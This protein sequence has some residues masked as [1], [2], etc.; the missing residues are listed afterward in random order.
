MKVVILKYL[1]MRSL[2]EC[3]LKI[4]CK[5]FKRYNAPFQVVILAVH[6]MMATNSSRCSQLAAQLKFDQTRGKEYQ[7]KSAT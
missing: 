3:T 4:I 6:H 7:E 1:I 2:P 5:T